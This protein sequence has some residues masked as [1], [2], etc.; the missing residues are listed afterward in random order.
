MFN[1][2][3]RI[4]HKSGF[5]LVDSI[6]P[7]QQFLVR[8]GRSGLTSPNQMIKCNVQGHYTVPI[9]KLMQG[10]L[11]LK[12]STLP[13]RQCI[14]LSVKKVLTDKQVCPGSPKSHL[15]LILTVLQGRDA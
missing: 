10:T 9:I 5:V 15:T 4:C 2:F 7:R 14:P 3:Q 13:P 6:N 11:N 1:V 8:S 12:S